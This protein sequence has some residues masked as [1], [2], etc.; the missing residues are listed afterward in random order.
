M[1]LGLLQ[2]LP[3]QCCET[4]AQAAAQATLAGSR[5]L[6]RS[7]QGTAGAQPSAAPEKLRRLT[8]SPWAVAE[9]LQHGTRVLAHRMHCMPESQTCKKGNQNHV[10]CCCFTCLLPSLD[11]DGTVVTSTAQL[12]SSAASTHAAWMTSASST[13]TCSDR[14]RGKRASGRSPRNVSSEHVLPCRRTW[15]RYAVKDHFPLP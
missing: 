6:H 13:D 9:V 10:L 11:R 1:S 5:P 3:F 15:I 2:L 4:H 7:V 8:G 12:R 14:G